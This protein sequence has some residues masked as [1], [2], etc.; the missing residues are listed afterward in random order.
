MA[1]KRKVIKTLRVKNQQ[2][3]GVLARVLNA[4]AMGGGDIGDIRTLSIGTFYTIRDITVLC[5]DEKQLG[6]IVQAIQGLKESTLEAVIDDV[7]ERHQGGKIKV[8]PSRPVQSI[9]D[10]RKI[11]TAGVAAISN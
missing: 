1:L 6:E 9:E 10:L 2:Q 8:V 5:N 3:V 4:I 11:Y 7:M